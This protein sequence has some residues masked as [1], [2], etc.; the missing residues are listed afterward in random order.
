MGENNSKWSNG[1]RINPKTIQ[2]TPQLNS[3]KIKWK[4]SRSVMSNSLQPVDSSPQSFSIHRIL[5]ART[6]EWVAI[7][8]S[9][10]SSWPRDWTQ[11][12]HI[13]GRHFNLCTTREALKYKNP[14]TNI[15]DFKGGKEARLKEKGGGGG[16]V[17]KRDGLTDVSCHLQLPRHHGTFPWASREGRTGTQPYQK[18]D[19]TRTRIWVLC[20]EEVISLQSSSLTEGPSTRFLCPGPRD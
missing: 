7:S 10:G 1:Q 4:W 3:R 8:F 14:S 18:S 9:K 15:K 16:G 12:S 19:Q 13:A 5:Q 20:Q 6:L 2:A 17:G 11:V